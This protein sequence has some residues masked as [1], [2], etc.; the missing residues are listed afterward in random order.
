MFQNLGVKLLCLFVAVLLWV[1]AASQD[2]QER[3]VALPLR[4]VGLVDSLAVA[5][6]R[7][8]ETVTVRMRESRL[9]LLLSDLW[10]GDLGEVE[11]DLTGVA[12][13]RSRIPLIPRD[14]RTEATAL[15]IVSPTTI[16][17][18]VQRRLSRAVAVRLRTEGS[19][20][21]GYARSGAE[22]ITPE[23]VTVEGPEEIVSTVE[24]ISTTLVTLDRRRASFRATAA[25][26]SPHPDVVLR[27]REVMVSVGIEE[28][29]EQV[30]EDVLVTVFTDG[31]SAPE[32]VRLD[33][34][35]V[36]VTV[37][38]AAGIVGRLRAEDIS[39]RVPIA[40]DLRGVAEIPVEVVA[41]DG[42]IR[43]AVD[44]LRIQVFVDVPDS[45]GARED[46][47]R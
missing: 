5:R 27:P 26:V 42:V 45:T 24:E 46:G 34:T 9:R 12:L 1:Q 37:V 3:E 38:G 7:M 39:V 41:L 10:R 28:V 8:P 19:L 25:L 35:T 15:S 29:V 44:P 14:V 2:F 6:S 21:A 20:P 36:R 47:S 33:P 17:V 43:T 30:F 13:G 22:E 40:S 11:L 16:D 31:D 18:R 4:V 23:S 32:R